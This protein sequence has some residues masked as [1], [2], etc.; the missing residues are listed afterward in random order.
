MSVGG[1]DLRRKDFEQLKGQTHEQEELG[2]GWCQT[3]WESDVGCGDC[4]C[5]KRLEDES[6]V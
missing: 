1:L 5:R 3:Q 2:C 4:P 6:P